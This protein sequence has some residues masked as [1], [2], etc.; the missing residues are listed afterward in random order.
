MT[1]EELRVDLKRFIEDEY[2]VAVTLQGKRL[3]V[4]DQEPPLIVLVT[5]GKEPR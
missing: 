5:R 4:S 2:D 1:P 3:V